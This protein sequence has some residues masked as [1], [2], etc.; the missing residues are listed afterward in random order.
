MFSLLLYATPMTVKSTFISL[1]TIFSKQ[2]PCLTFII[3]NAKSP[4]RAETEDANPGMNVTPPR[5]H[6]EEMST[7]ETYWNHI[8]TETIPGQLE[9]TW[10]QLITDSQ[11]IKLTFEGREATRTLRCVLKRSGLR[12]AKLSDTADTADSMRRRRP[13]IAHDTRLS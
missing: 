11:E 12:A 2:T 1:Q 13:I 4:E 8:S 9:R 7:E 5:T 6:T 10:G 3:G